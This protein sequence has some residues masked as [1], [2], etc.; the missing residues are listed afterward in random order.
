[1]FDYLAKLFDNRLLAPHGFCI[2]WRPELLWTHVISDAVIFG[3]YMTIP[4]ALAVII[5]RRRDIPFGWMLWCFAL[6]ITA[7]GMTH[8]MGIWT[9][10]NP[11]YGVE[12]VIKAITAL[13]S[14][15]TA[16]ALW[17]LIP[18]AVS[19]PTP[20][21]LKAVN[22]ELHKR[23][24]ERDL[25]IAE[26]QH[27]KTQRQQSEEALVQARKMDALGQLTG[28]IAHDF[29]N[30]LQAVQGSLELIQRRVADPETVR[31]LA[32]GAMQAAERGSRLTGQ[33]LAFARSKQLKMEV[34]VVSDFLNEARELLSGAAGN[35]VE[36]AVELDCGDAAVMADR[37]QLELA[38]L[39]LIIN[40]RDAMD[41]GGRVTVRTRKV[42]FAL[43]QPDLDV[44]EY[45]EL[46]VA[47]DGPGMSDEVR[48]RAFEPFFSTKGV[49]RGTGLGLSQ[50]YA[51][52]RQAGGSAR[53]ESVVGQG[54][55]VSLLLPLAIRPE[56]VETTARPAAPA[57]AHTGEVLVVDDDPDVR[58]FVTAALTALG[59]RVREAD[60]GRQALETARAARPDLVLLDYAMPGMTG[61][62][63]AEA[64]EREHAD[65]PIL[66]MTGFA[67]AA[68]L[69]PVLGR[70]AVVLRKPFR[71]DELAAAVA[72]VLG[73]PEP[74]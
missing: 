55:R 41:G 37:T 7:C 59:H 73:S 34:F 72:N 65:L 12:A 63:T 74:A 21:A 50:A 3:A 22:E 66:F 70:R 13:A 33:L 5:Q 71:M 47:D 17:L 25:A 23:I 18:V 10:W 56:T 44:G 60:G 54:T 51:A 2:L 52:A 64:L 38:L 42:A 19:L 58:L 53:I 62:E 26:L 29:N 27:E 30:L 1:V 57:E 20:A 35:M 9:L 46:S 49:G 39:N 61:A 14:I 69:E 48:A 4:A 68:D 16:V 31:R 28:G 45:L 67:D 40:A 24:A 8:L 15:G 6:F 11:D 43:P 36:L 32:D